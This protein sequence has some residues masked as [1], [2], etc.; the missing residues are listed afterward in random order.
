MEDGPRVYRST[1][2]VQYSTSARPRGFT[3][4][5]SDSRWNEAQNT[6][7]RTYQKRSPSWP[8]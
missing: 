3:F 6:G 1:A 2:V 7:L 5:G 8:W 4:S